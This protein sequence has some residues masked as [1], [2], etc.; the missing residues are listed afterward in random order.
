MYTLIDLEYRKFIDGVASTRNFSQIGTKGNIW[1]NVQT[2]IDTLSNVVDTENYP[3]ISIFGETS[4]VATLNVY[5][6]SDGVDFYLCEDLTSKVNVP[7]GL[8]FHIF[9][10]A[11]VRYF[12]LSSSADVLATVTVM[13]KP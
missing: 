2:G 8:T 9:F 13:A 4:A 1:N 3:N 5:V 6:S 7:S 10:T 11:G 12:A